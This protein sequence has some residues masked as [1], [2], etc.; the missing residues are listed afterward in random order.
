[1]PKL[2]VN[3]FSADLPGSFSCAPAWII[4]KQLSFATAHDLV[5]PMSCAW[6][7]QGVPF[8]AAHVRA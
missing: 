3:P 4:S 6:L 5:T 7:A 2:F 1:M 8:L